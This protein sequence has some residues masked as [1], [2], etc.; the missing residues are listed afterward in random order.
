MLEKQHP[1]LDEMVKTL[2]R[3]YGGIWTQPIVINE[4]QL[5]QR[6][7]VASDYVPFLL[8]RLHQ[9]NVIEYHKSHGLPEIQFL[10]NR[11][12]PEFLMLNQQLMAELK[13]AYTER[14]ECMQAYARLNPNQCRNQHL[15]AFFGQNIQEPCGQCDLC[16]QRTKM[17]QKFDPVAVKNTILRLLTLEGPLSLSDITARFTQY[18]P[19]PVR[20]LLRLMLSERLLRKNEKGQL[21]V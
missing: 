14:V 10:H 4:F 11:V 1:E 7:Q 3:M 12:K 6:M 9:L 2:L 21:N 17:M 8:D 20:E 13:Q 16:R 18:K 19:E 5:A 15:L